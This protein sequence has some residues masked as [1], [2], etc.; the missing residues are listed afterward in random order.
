VSEPAA[1]PI[2]E[3]V[4]EP[5]KDAFNDHRRVFG[6]AALLLLAMTIIFVGVGRHPGQPGTDT[7]WQAIGNFDSSVYRWVQDHRNDVVTA[8]SKGFSFI[9]GGIV[10]VPF[11]ILIAIYL[12]YR[13]RRR[14][15]A[16]WVI[17]WTVAEVGLTLA[18]AWYMRARPPAP[19]VVTHDASFPSG[20]AVAT[21]S[22]AVALVLVSMP[23][24]HRRRKWE[25]AAAGAAFLM[26]LSRVYLN[27]HWFSDVVAGTLLGAGV[28]LGTAAL[29]T[30]ARIVY[31]RRQQPQSR[32]APPAGGP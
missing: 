6:Y 29:V 11:R 21:A 9:G 24:G 32:G 25:L 27:A 16:T 26:D 1:E 12:L 20:H 10:T 30:E 13:R 2:T 19:L 18:K 5:I 22:I 7:T 3:T 4:V 31:R 28:A 8:I 14:G 15:F 23:Y 17:T